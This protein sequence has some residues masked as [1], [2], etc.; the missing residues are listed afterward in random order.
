MLF[1]RA[2][3]YALMSLVLIARHQEPQDTESLAHTLGISKSFLAKIL[4]GLAR[5]KVLQ[6]FKGAKGGFVLAKEPEMISVLDI[7]RAID[8]KSANVFEC[9][10]A[11]EDCPSGENKAAICAIWPFLNKLQGRIDGFLSDITLSDMLTD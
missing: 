1:T 9:S 7:I 5:E 6:S 2:S 8:G 10:S 3:E 4:Q 11:L